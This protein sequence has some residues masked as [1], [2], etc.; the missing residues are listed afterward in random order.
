MNRIHPNIF[1]NRGWV[2]RMHE[3]LSTPSRDVLSETP[4]LQPDRFNHDTRN[5][6]TLSGSMPEQLLNNSSHARDVLGQQLCKNYFV[7]T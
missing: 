4:F 3:G 5:R 2:S 7:G 1:E 6:V